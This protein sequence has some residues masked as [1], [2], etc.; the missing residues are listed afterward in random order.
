MYNPEIHHR[1]S[2]RLRGFDYSSSGAYFVTLCSEERECLFGGVCDGEMV[3]NDAGKII[4]RTWKTLE[5]KFPEIIQGEF[6][7]MPNHFHGIICITDTVGALLAAPAFDVQKCNNDAAI[8]E[9]KGAAS[10]APTL[11]K[12]M[13]IFKSISAIEVNRILDRKGQPLWQRNYYDRIIRDEKELAAISEYIALNPI[14]WAEDKE[15]PD[16]TGM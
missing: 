16:F 4:K 10:S 12:I 9:N 3:L 8:A 1:Q 6:V 7:I 11:G 13:R 2:I 14:R 5:I 15:N